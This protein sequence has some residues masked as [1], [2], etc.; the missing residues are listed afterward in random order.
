MT[1]EMAQEE[2]IKASIGDIYRIKK[3]V[4]AVV[5]NVK[6]DGG[7]DGKIIVDLN[8]LTKQE[9]IDRLLDLINKYG[10]NKFFTDQLD[11]LFKG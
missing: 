5:T 6:K 3:G 7:V 1:I 4:Y 9:A 11:K 8:K 10:S 2:K